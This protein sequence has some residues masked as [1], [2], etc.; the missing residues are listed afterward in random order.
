LPQQRAHGEPMHPARDRRLTTARVAQTRRSGPANISP[1]PRQKTPNVA[2]ARE[3][4]R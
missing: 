4:M 1:Q 2:A 3:L